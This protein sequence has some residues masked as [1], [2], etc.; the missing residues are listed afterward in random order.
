LINVRIINAGN[1][2]Y[3]FNGNSTSQEISGEQKGDK[4]LSFFHSWQLSPAIYCNRAVDFGS[5]YLKF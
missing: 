2:S 1:I 4:Y 3:D 5:N